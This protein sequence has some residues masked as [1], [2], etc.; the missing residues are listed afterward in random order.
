LSEMTGVIHRNH[1]RVG[2]CKG[3]SRRALCPERLA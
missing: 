3:C 2:K 1:E